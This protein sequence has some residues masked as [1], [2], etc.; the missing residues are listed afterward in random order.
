MHNTCDGCID[1]LGGN[2]CYLNLEME[3]ADGDREMY[4]PRRENEFADIESASVWAQMTYPA[5]YRIVKDGAMYV[6]HGEG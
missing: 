1:H 4:R 6:V 5:G 2:H 3:C